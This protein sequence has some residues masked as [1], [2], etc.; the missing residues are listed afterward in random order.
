M[1]R[2][3][4]NTCFIG[5]S[6]LSKN[7]TQDLVAY[8][9]NMQFTWQCTDVSLAYRTA[10]NFRGRKVSWISEF[11]LRKLSRIACICCTKGCHVPKFAAKTFANSHKTTKFRQVF[12]LE[13]FLL[14]GTV[15]EF[16]TVSLVSWCS[17]KM[18]SVLMYTFNSLFWWM[19]VSSIG[20]MHN[21]TNLDLVFIS[22]S[23]LNVINNFYLASLWYDE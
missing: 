17:Q 3:T 6:A 23:V 22:P 19:W 8:S 11:S 5:S 14:Y 10:G 2:P 21:D 13:S 1:V 4:M 18:G 20:D 9:Y 15:H 7:S 16:R 12:F